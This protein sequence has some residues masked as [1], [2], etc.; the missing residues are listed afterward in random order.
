MRSQGLRVLL[1]M[2]LALVAAYVNVAA[3]AE[4]AKPLGAGLVLQDQ[5]PLRGA[6]RDSAPLQANLWRGEALEIRG[7]RLD[8]YQVWDYRRERGGWLRKS[9]LYRLPS[10]ANE[11]LATLRLVRLQQGAE[12]LGL[13]LAAA[14]VQSASREQLNGAGGTEAL[15]ALGTLA[16]RMADRANLGNKNSETQT[17]AQLDVA[18]RYGLRFVSFNLPD[19]RVQLCYDG[20]AFRRV[21][22]MPAPAEAQ[23]RAAL[24]LTRPDCADPAA[25][26]SDKEKLDAWRAE[27]LSHVEVQDLAPHWKNRV[28]MR[29]AAVQASLAFARREVAA[30]T[31]AAQQSLADFASLQAADLAED[32]QPTWNDTAMR[33]NAMRWAASPRL[34]SREFGKLLMNLSVTP[35]GEQCLS[36]IEGNPAKPLLR[37][38]SFG[39][40]W[41]ASASLN[42]EGTAIAI[43]AQPLEGWRELWVL[44]KGREGWSLQVL[45][46][47][48]ATPGLGYVEFAG[49]VPGGKQVLVS[50]EARAEG[51]YARR[52]FELLSLD[53]LAT[54]RQA[55]EPQLLGAFQRW[56]DPAW[57]R[58]SLALR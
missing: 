24:A 36:L 28:L 11:L 51:R 34:A 58:E 38:C 48:A 23:A 20:D 21:L 47:A 54:E 35:D 12:A 25:L 43:A 2:G 33:V 27:V 19:G 14:Y 26:P 55:G 42:R 13:G 4:A 3:A 6:A 39:Q 8:H 16:E 1:V 49:W 50:R 57:K 9:Q 37:R 31:V 52:T 22:S 53:T 30:S 40:V 15:D 17:A 5:A 18:A 46:P 44:R 10:D 32:D 45:P 56:Q 41:L 7:E 29:R